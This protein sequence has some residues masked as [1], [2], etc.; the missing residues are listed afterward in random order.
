MK[1]DVEQF[2]NTYM[3]IRQDNFFYIIYNFLMALIC[4]ISS[5]MY[6][7]LSAFGKM[8]ENYDLF[9]SINFYDIIFSISFSIDMIIRFFIAY[10]DQNKKQILKFQE[11]AMNYL[12]HDFVFDLLTV[13]PI[14]RILDPN[15]I[16]NHHDEINYTQEEFDDIKI[17][18]IYLIKVI[19]IKK[20]YYL[21]DTSKFKKMV[22]QYYE[23]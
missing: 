20:A 16:S 10:E 17:H 13:V 23:Q 4:I 5:F 9:E 19:R 22:F 1:G 3:I 6:A 8:Y 2:I 15:Q 14:V 18:L 7:Y 11:I 12:K 21:L